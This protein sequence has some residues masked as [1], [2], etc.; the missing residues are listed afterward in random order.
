MSTNARSVILADLADLIGTQVDPRD[1]PDALYLGLEHVGSSRFIRIGGGIAADVQSSKF[2][3]KKGDV[4]YGKLRPYLDKAVL[5]E[6]DGVCTTELLVLRA[7]EG[8]DPLFLIG[9]VH[10]RD[11]IEHAISGTTGSQHPRT[12]WRRIS[13]FELPNFTPDEQAKIAYIIWTTHNSL[14]ACEE[15]IDT[16]VQLKRTAMRE[17]FTRGL[18]GA[19]QKDTEIGLVPETWQPMALDD[20]AIVQT[21]VAKGRK[22][23]DAE[24]VDVPYLRV[25]NV[26]DGH[27]DLS[28]MKEIHIRRS[29][30]ERYRLQ[31]GDVV[32]TEGGDFDKLGRGFIWRGE[33]DLCVHQNHV[34]AVRPDRKHLLPEF[35]A[36]LAQSAYGKAYFLK[37]AHKTT[38]LACINST[39]LKAF[40]V[41]VPPTLDEQREIVEI[42]DAIDRKIDLHKRKRAVLDDLFKALLHKLM[43][44]EIRVSDLDLPALGQARDLSGA[45]EAGPIRAT[46][47]AA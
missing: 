32:L 7:K 39:K 16:G 12:S 28:E 44:G 5:A 11:F 43:T 6:Q 8:I 25:A 3:F 24:M 18:R 30:V 35:F 20:C 2:T 31:T 38:N 17:L 33:L 21:G 23:A 46:G 13:E 4:L 42:L 9:V 10:C 22:F 29:E 34:F 37:V 15:A 40:P 26:Q 45:N 27:L 36:Y 14:L 19:A 1:Q 41:L 47:A